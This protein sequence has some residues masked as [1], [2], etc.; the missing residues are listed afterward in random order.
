[1]DRALYGPDG[2][3]VSGGG[4]GAHFRTSVHT[5]AGFDAAVLRL[6]GLRVVMALVFGTRVDRWRLLVLILGGVA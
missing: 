3:F 2:F 1:M 5:A 4:P 6:I